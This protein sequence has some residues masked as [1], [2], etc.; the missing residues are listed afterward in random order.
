MPGARSSVLVVLRALGPFTRM[1]KL[2]ELLAAIHALGLLLAESVRVGRAGAV[3]ESSL[4]MD[5][6][7][8][9]NPGVAY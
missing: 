3:Y 9:N 2:L 5:L 1:R 6:P 7:P 4:D 8:I